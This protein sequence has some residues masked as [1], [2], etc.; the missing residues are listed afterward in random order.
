MLMAQASG[1]P[2]NRAPA[3]PGA[4]ETNPK[5]NPVAIHTAGV[6]RRPVAASELKNRPSSLSHFEN[7]TYLATIFADANRSASTA[8]S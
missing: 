2:S 8:V 5:P 7:Q 1:K 4:G 6:I 3:V